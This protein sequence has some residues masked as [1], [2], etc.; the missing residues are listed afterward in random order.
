MKAR[1]TKRRASL[2]RVE[3]EPNRSETIRL[4]G[5]CF[6]VGLAALLQQGNPDAE[7]LCVW[8]ADGPVSEV[9]HNIDG[10]G[11]IVIDVGAFRWRL[12]VVSVERSGETVATEDD[13]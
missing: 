3:G 4:F 13:Q 1:R 12:A 10:E 5:D 2:T 11:R 8:C 7:R 9:D 6:S